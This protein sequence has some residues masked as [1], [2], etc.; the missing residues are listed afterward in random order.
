MITN[1]PQLHLDLPHNA[2][3]RVWKNTEDSFSSPGNRWQA[4]LDRLGVDT[5]LAWLK[6]EHSPHARI[7]EKEATLA[8]F[9]EVVNGAAIEFDGYRA[10]LIATSAIDGEELRVPQE[11]IDIPSWAGDYYL[12]IYVDPEVGEIRVLGYTT[13]RNLKAKAEYDPSD[14]SYSMAGEDLVSD[15]EI[16]WLAH[17]LCPQ[18]PLRA[19]IAA[20]AQ[21]PLEQAENL[22][23][24]LGDKTIIRPRLAVPFA[25]WGALLE[26]HGW[27]QRLYQQ[28]LGLPE[29]WS[30]QEWWQQG[31]SQLGREFGW[32]TMVMQPN[33]VLARGQN[34]PSNQVLCRQLSIAGQAYELRI[35]PTGKS[36]TWRFEL[37]SSEERPIPPGLK[38]RL[39]NEDLSPF[40]NNEDIAVIAIERLYLE[41]QLTPGD[42][43]VWQTEPLPADYAIEV[44]RF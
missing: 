7:W 9:W 14:R 23:H 24:R 2:V 15:I 34:I 10:I 20:I 25:L 42:G 31:V 37:Q 28:R 44:L 26:H 5:F 30:I 39:L 21:I 36:H 13:H 11:W 41:V 40:P 3:D 29:Q 38:L 27:R 17:Q 6:A 35:L 32:E 22:L 4:L 8:S 1:S 19:P 12:S 18:E 16:L 43:L 33:L